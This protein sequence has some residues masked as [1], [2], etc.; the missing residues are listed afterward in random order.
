[1]ENFGLIDIDPFVILTTWSN[2]RVGDD[3]I[4]KRLDRLLVSADLLDHDYLFRQW[5]GC[6]G[7]FDHN[8]VFLQVMNKGLK[9]R[10]PFKFNAHWLTD[11]NLVCLLKD[12]WVVYNDYLSESPASQFSTNLKRIKDVSI[13]WS[14]KKKER[15]IKDLVEIELLLEESFNKVGFGFA[16]NEDKESLTELES[17]KGNILLDREHEAR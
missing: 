15:D 14:V 1:M 7:D 12:T 10:S 2:R 17:R 4:C 13:Y 3:S 9:D 11:E 6:G 16:S 5:V 8:H